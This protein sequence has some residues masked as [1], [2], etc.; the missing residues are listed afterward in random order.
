MT[1]KIDHIAI[2]VNSLEDAIKMYCDIFGL[3][4]DDIKI[5]IMKE[6]KIKTAMLPVGDIM[7]Q[8]LESTDSD[9]DVAKHIAEHGEGMHH[10]G[11]Q[12][13]GI[14]TMLKTLKE[15]NVPLIDKEPRPGHGTSKIAFINPKSPEVLI[16]LVEY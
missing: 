3:K 2:A 1:T 8:L 6:R 7:I 10:L 9:G 12:I 4:V 14:Q 11:V 5:G 15:N 13:S 16:E